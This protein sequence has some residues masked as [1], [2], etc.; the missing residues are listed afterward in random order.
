MQKGEVDRRKH[1]KA[2]RKSKE[3]KTGYTAEVVACCYSMFSAK[4]TKL[5]EN[6]SSILIS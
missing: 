1:G 2:E 3:N 6:I 5:A 4:M